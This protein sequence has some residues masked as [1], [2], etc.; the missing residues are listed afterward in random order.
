MSNNRKQQIFDAILESLE[1]NSATLAPLKKMFK[2][3]DQ[4]EEILNFI[5]EIFWE[6]KFNPDDKK[7]IKNIKEYLELQIK[8]N[9]K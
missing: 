7:I 6:E 1:E 9:S 2:D 4:L 3:K 5:Y 8:A